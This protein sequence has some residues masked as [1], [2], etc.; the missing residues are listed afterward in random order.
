MK[1]LRRLA[2]EFELD[3]NNRK[4]TKVNVSESKTCVDEPVW[5]ER[6]RGRDG[7]ERGREGGRGRGREG[8]RGREREGEGEGAY[9]N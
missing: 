6:E 1:I 5:T 4:S 9:Q 7:E 3:Q 8:G 2:Y